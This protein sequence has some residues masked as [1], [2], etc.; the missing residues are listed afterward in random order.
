MVGA[1][2]EEEATVLHNDLIRLNPTDQQSA[3]RM[4]WRLEVLQ[5]N[6]PGDLNIKVSLI[7]AY[8]LLGRRNDAVSLV[9]SLWHRRYHIDG[10][11]IRNYSLH[12]FA[13]GM[14]ERFLEL[15]AELTEALS[16]AD[17]PLLVGLRL[18]AFWRL[19][20]LE[21]VKSFNQML[22]SV[23]ATRYNWKDYLSVIDEIGLSN[24][25]ATHQRVIRE[26]TANVQ[27]YSTVKLVQDTG[28]GQQVA[29][30]IYTA[31]GYEQR[32]ALEDRIRDNLDSYYL[33]NRL[34]PSQCWDAAPV[35][36]LSFLSLA[37]NT[38]L[39]EAIE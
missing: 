9:D 24:H 15:D 5:R 6:R 11:M 28:S 10:N 23:S 22:I 20:N 21:K 38:P 35:I 34:D 32:I 13:L 18:T 33:Q 4:A 14:F 29:T 37:F 26:E 8:C 12:L 1:V 16:S 25:F 39:Q 27:L 7:K 30:F 17:D 36:V 2:P 19:G 31:E 3:A